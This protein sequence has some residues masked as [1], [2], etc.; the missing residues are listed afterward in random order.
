LQKIEAEIGDAQ[1]QKASIELTLAD[2]TVYEEPRKT[3]LTQLLEKQH[4]CTTLL[5]QL[6]SEWLQVQESLEQIAS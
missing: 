1:R 3:E 2:S 4:R 5:E 6:E